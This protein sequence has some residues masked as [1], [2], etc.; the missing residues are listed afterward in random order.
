MSKLKNFEEQY[1]NLC[2]FVEEYGW[3][4]IGESQHINSFVRAYALGGTVYHGKE[5]YPNMEAALSDLDSGI[6]EYMDVNGIWD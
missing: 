2:R 1:P 3:I 4:E 5:S 6:K